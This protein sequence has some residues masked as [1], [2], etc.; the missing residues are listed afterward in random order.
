M[1]AGYQEDMK[2]VIRKTAD[3][4]KRA[5]DQEGMNQVIRQA[6]EAAKRA[7]DLDEQLD[8]IKAEAES[9]M[10]TAKGKHAESAMKTAKGKHVDYVDR[11]ARDLLFYVKRVREYVASN[12]AKEAAAQALL[13]GYIYQR[14][15]VRPFEGAV[16]L[17]REVGCYWRDHWLKVTEL[18]R[19]I[20]EFIGGDDAVPLAKL[21][22]AAWRRGYQPDHRG[23]VD[24]ALSVL[25]QKLADNEPP[26][27]AAL[28]IEADRVTVSSA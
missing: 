10:K 7:A 27:R 14:L 6:A 22:K 24:K 25:N 5:A 11:D 4:A 1:R 15:R 18:E 26:V 2:K 9:T 20:L 21:V 17:G 8:R 13:L 16:N 3:P 12:N 19:S 23:K 28:H